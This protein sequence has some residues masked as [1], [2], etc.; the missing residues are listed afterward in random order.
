MNFA[1]WGEEGASSIVWPIL[2]S[3]ICI[4]LLVFLACVK[5]ISS[6]GKAMYVTVIFPIVILLIFFFRAI[7]LEGA[8]PGIAY[9]FK[10]KLEKVFS[11]DAWKDAATQ[12]FFNLGLGQ[13]SNHLVRANITRWFCRLYYRV[14]TMPWNQSRPVPFPK[15]TGPGGT[16]TEKSWPVSDSGMIA[17]YLD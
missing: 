11:I 13:C 12:T 9:L 6:A 8:G 3:N 1:S 14:R 4:W 16:G 17:K 5:G 2:V 10:P 15:N 7:T